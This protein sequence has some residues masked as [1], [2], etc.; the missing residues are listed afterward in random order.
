MFFLVSEVAFAFQCFSNWRKHLQPQT[1]KAHV[2]TE[3]QEML[4]Y[5]N[6]S[7]FSRKPEQ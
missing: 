4:R 7:S 6:V 1:D 5:L 3:Q 2:P